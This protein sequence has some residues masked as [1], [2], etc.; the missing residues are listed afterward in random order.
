MN[1]MLM[2]RP[3]DLLIHPRNMR[4]FYPASQ[5]R[6]MADSILAAGG[7]LQPLIIVKNPERYS[8]KYLVV[9]GNMRLTAGQLLENKCPPLKC[10]IVAQK[11]AEQMLSM[12][13]ANQIRYDVDPVSEGLHYKALQD[14][15]MTVRKISK[16]TGVYEVRITNRKILADLPKS[17]QQLIVEEKLPASPEAAR[18]LLELPEKK[19]IKLAE[20]LAK[21]PNVKIRTVVTAVERLTI[22][23]TKDKKLKHP[24]SGLS[25]AAISEKKGTTRSLIRTA[26]K[27]TCQKCNQ[28]EGKLRAT[29]EPAWSVVVH[30]G[31]TTCTQCPLKDMSSICG[32]CPAVQL[33]KKLVGDE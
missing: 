14:E 24:A 6:E 25:G 1:K 2:L 10:E 31:D 19:A 26:A 28:Y 27:N 21:N 3:K 7:V 16:L 33:L 13:I 8:H 9:D 29:P 5:V 22:G 20:R 17:I 11:K 12:I 23:N 30:A 15:G 4:R 32:S 18:A